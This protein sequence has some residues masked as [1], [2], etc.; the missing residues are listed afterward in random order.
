MP[1]VIGAIRDEWLALGDE[2]GP[3]THRRSDSQHGSVDRTPR[4]GAHAQGPVDG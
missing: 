2:F 4:G 1:E 3:A